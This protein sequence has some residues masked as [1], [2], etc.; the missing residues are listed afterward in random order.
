MEA[1]KAMR[2]ALKSIDMDLACGAYERLPQAQQKELKAA[3]VDFLYKY[4]KIL[5]DGLGY[6]R[7]GDK[8]GWRDRWLWLYYRLR[9]FLSREDTQGQ[10][11]SEV[12]GKARRHR[13]YQ[14]VEGYHRRVVG[15]KSEDKGEHTGN[16]TEST[17]KD[18]EAGTPGEGLTGTVGRAGFSAEYLQEG[19]GVMPQVPTHTQGGQVPSGG[20]IQT[21]DQMSKLSDNF[22]TEEATRSTKAIQ[23]H[24]DNSM[25][26]K[27]QANA[28]LFATNVLQPIRDRIGKPFDITSWYRSP[29]LN[30]AVKG[31]STSAHLTGMAI[32]F[33]IRGM[34]TKESYNTVLVALKDLRITFEELINERNTKTG[35]TWVHLALKKTGNHNE[36]F[37]K[38]VSE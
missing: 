18:R 20:G 29:A 25:D 28:Q 38:E 16:D 11:G 13:I 30:K 6:S 36:A 34:S 31:V 35:S 15:R 33:N 4:C 37:Y 24:I 32:D 2:K 19:G 21:T 5:K 17:V 10:G 1:S 26:A 12:A 27:T 7:S 22:T 23:L 14:A 8:Y 3:T 9:S